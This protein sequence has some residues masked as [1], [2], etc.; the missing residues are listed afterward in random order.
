M[1]RF[2]IKVVFVTPHWLLFLTSPAMNHPWMR[3]KTLVDM[4]KLST[5]HGLST[6]LIACLL[7]E[8]WHRGSMGAYHG[9]FSCSLCQN[10]EVTALLV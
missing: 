9:T 5:A 6:S 4:V 8:G 3:D 2:N 7:C 10:L 1:R